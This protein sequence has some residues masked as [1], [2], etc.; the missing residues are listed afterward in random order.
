M[1][2]SYTSQPRAIWRSGCLT[3]KVAHTIDLKATIIWRWMLTQESGHLKHI[4][5]KFWSSLNIDFT[6]SL[7][8]RRIDQR[9]INQRRIDQRR[10]NQRRIDQRRITALEFSLCNSMAIW[11]YSALSYH[12]SSAICQ[13]F[14][15]C[16]SMA[17]CTLDWSSS[18]AL[19][20]SSV[21]LAFKPSLA[22]RFLG[23]FL[24][25]FP[26]SLLGFLSYCSRPLLP[27][28]SALPLSSLSPSCVITR[29][30]QS[31]A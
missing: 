27:S 3:A 15:R 23:L 22:L 1:N 7:A 8:R 18:V 29:L 10:I 25:T 30:D 4:Y 16:D 26:L 19:W 5:Q 17:I 28:L 20:G 14:K 13:N 24:A 11:P 6:A 9:R 12:C 2:T 21:V 31:C